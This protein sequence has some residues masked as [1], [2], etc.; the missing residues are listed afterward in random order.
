M[1]RAFE[2]VRGGREGENYGDRGGFCFRANFRL[3]KIFFFP[4]WRQFSVFKVFSRQNLIF[5]F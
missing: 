5:Y 3:M 1:A 4:N 2:D